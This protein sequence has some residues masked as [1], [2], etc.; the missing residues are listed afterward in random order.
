[1][2][3]EDDISFQEAGISP[4]PDTERKVLNISMGKPTTFLP[5]T[6]QYKRQ[7]D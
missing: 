5:V 4:G 2:R 3:F 7:R 1:M 6:L